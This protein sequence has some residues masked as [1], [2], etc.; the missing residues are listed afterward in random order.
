MILTL[1]GTTPSFAALACHSQDQIDSS[2]TA[3]EKETEING[4]KFTYFDF[5]GPITP[6]PSLGNLTYFRGEYDF[7]AKVI[8]GNQQCEVKFRISM[9]LKGG[10]WTAHWGSR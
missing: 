5:P 3:L 2:R 10:S 7:V 6:D 1:S 8:Y 4:N 9:M